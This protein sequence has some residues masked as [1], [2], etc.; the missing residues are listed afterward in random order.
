MAMEMAPD[1]AMTMETG[2][3]D[4]A[5]H[6]TSPGNMDADADCEHC[7]PTACAAAIS[8]DVAM[9]SACE[10]DVQYSPDSR[11]TNLVL[12]DLPVE[13]PV[14]IAP[15]F[16]IAT[17]THHHI[18]LPGTHASSRA[19]GVQPLLNLLNCVFLI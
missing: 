3:S 16:G 6:A 9:S 8:C 14:S 2:H 7:P 18:V 17:P 5:A 4:H 1:Q 19:P 10:P 13:P 11:R 15:A 12:K